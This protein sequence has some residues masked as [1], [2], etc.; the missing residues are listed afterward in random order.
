VIK[1]KQYKTKRKYL[2]LTHGS[3][4]VVRKHRQRY[5]KRADAIRFIGTYNP[6]Y[7]SYIKKL[8]NIQ[9]EKLYA[10]KN[11]KPE[12]ASFVAMLKENSARQEY[13]AKRKDE[14]KRH[15]Q[16]KDSSY[17]KTGFMTPSEF[18][19]YR[20]IVLKARE[21]GYHIPRVDLRKGPLVVD[22]I[23]IPRSFATDGIFL[24]DNDLTDD[25]EVAIIL[26]DDSASTKKK[27]MIF[28][29]ELGHVHMDQVHEKDTE[30]KADK[31]AADILDVPMSEIM[32]MDIDK[33]IYVNK[34]LGK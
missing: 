13:L 2:R 9:H 12:E 23:N 29:H 15:T 21:K 6:N 5:P 22:E 3:I 25:K 16:A 17:H 20:G 8:Q 26:I 33:D 18:K 10:P 31:I 11:V 24:P 14:T 34:Q 30:D 27:R 32:D 7:E 1:L 4:Q 19:M 28:A